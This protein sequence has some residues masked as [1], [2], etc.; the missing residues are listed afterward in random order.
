M[1][2]SSIAIDNRKPPLLIVHRL[3]KKVFQYFLNEIHK[4][5]HV[6][7]HLCSLMYVKCILCIC[8]A[9]SLHMCVSF[10][11]VTHVFC[12][13][14]AY[15]FNMLHIFIA[16]VLQCYAYFLHMLHRFFPDFMQIFSKCFLYSLRMLRVFVVYATCGKYP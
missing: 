12:I 9:Y 7:I 2:S 8:C 16:Y 4:I 11:Y 10:V 6:N 13:C 3:S 5:R 14:Y 1:I 15:F